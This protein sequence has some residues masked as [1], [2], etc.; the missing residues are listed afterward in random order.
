MLA[1]FLLNYLPATPKY[2]EAQILR[3]VKGAYDNV[4]FYR[5]LLADRGLTASD[6]KSLSDYVQ[7]FPRTDT[8][9]YRRIKKER[10][11]WFVMDRRFANKSLKRLRTSGSSGTPAEIIRTNSEFARIHGAK[12]VYM[13]VSAGVRPW[14]K[15]MAMLP[16]WD[17]K[18]RQHALQQFGIF[19]RHDASFLEDADTILKRLSDN[20]INVMFGRAGMMRMLAERCVGVARRWRQWRS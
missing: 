12:T 11:D 8:R 18:K 17:V 14:H 10:G 20:G 15:I 4:P 6:F 3:R 2:V 19:R 7:K 9:E 5:T 16:P 1:A 13:L